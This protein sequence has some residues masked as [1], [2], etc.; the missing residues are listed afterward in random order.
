[1]YIVQSKLVF[2]F[3]YSYILFQ[4][5]SKGNYLIGNTIKQYLLGFE[6]EGC[7]LTICYI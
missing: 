1:M 7:L 3:L 4:E 5:Y 6:N 2:Y